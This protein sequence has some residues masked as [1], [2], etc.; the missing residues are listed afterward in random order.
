[1]SGVLLSMIRSPSKR[2]RTFWGLEICVKAGYP[3]SLAVL[4]HQ[5]LQLGTPLYLE[6]HLLVVLPSNRPTCDFTFRW[7]V[8]S[9][10]FDLSSIFF[11]VFLIKSFG[12]PLSAVSR[13]LPHKSD[14]PRFQNKPSTEDKSI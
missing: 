9:S 7:I 4:I 12:P 3:L 14:F 1:M 6:E 13:Q 2:N 5:L 8:S 11:N 10:F